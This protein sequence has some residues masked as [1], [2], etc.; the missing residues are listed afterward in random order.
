M[1]TAIAVLS[2]LSQN[3][4]TYVSGQI[5]ATELGV[6]RSAIWK[7]IEALRDEG[8]L[9]DAVTNRG[10]ALKRREDLFSREKLERL[11]P[12]VVLH[13]FDTIDSTNRY[14]R[15][16]ASDGCTSPTLVLASSQSG[17]RGRLGRQ[18]ASPKGG[19]YLSLVLHPTS[20]FQEASLITSAAAVSAASAIEQVCSIKC[21]IKWV[22]D[23]FLDGKK[24]GGILT[25]GVMDVERGRF[26]S[27]V[28]GIGINFATP[29]QAYPP[30]LRPI[31][32]SLYEGPDRIPEGIDASTLVA[33]L[34]RLLIGYSNALGERLF[35]EEYRRRSIVL[36]KEIVILQ[37]KKE[38]RAK[39]LSIDENAHLVVVDSEGNE[40]V[41][42]SGEI[43][44]H[45]DA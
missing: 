7:A 5:L 14:A 41:L 37:Q 2:Y 39:A 33:T 42:A 15:Q 27:V 20:S 25:E 40:E 13:L 3:Q 24:V 38:R 9:I 4:D 23:L 6:S 34:V 28:V 35:L 31:V 19:I 45:L 30:A 16:L 32:K 10:Y 43:S 17:G 22:N 1:N 26:S 18:F 29:Q 8:H 36:G 12:G 44:I 11:L 21:G